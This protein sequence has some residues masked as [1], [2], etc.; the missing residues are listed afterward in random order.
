MKFIKLI[1]K[2][3][4]RNLRRT[5]LATAGI[6]LAVFVVTSVTALEAGFG[7][8][9]NSG[10]ETLLNV[11]EK[12][13]ACPISS[14]VFDTYLQNIRSLPSVIRAT[15]VLRAMYTYQR[16]ENLVPVEGVD[17][18][19]FRAIG[20]IRIQEG[21]EKDFGA[22]GDGALV[23]RR[24]AEHYGWRVGETVS[25]VEGL[26]FRVAGIFMSSNATYERQVLLHKTFLANL[27]RDEGKST[28][29]VVQVAGP[30]SVAPVSKSIDGAFANYPRP[31]KTQSEKA[32]REQE[33]KDF[34][35]IRMM[36]SGMVLAT[37]LV[38]V[39]GAA[40]SVSM[41]VRER[42]REVGI[43]RSLGFQRKHVL[44]ILIAES[45]LIG[46]IGGLIGVGAS[47]TLLA[48]ERMVG[49]IVPLIVGPG[50]AVFGLGMAVLIGLLGALVPAIVASRARII[51]TLRTVD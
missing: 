34:N 26:T 38:S 28:Y 23:G 7:S 10:G 40:N 43:L 16:K 6:S 36:L 8:L 11:Y 35:A 45:I 41:S 48:S 39:F 12:N 19:T 49:G 20:G 2:N 37:I 47:W 30:G 22:N 27:K 17:F 24:L 46:L 21:S 3:L 18:E 29:L 33:S 15:G 9:A 31:T 51:D 44:E 50:T 14:R 32:A 5:T 13:V 25:M 42:T 1:A 4:S